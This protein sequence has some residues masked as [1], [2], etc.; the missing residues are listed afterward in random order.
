MGDPWSGWTK[1]SPLAKPAEPDKVVRIPPS[2]DLCLMDSGALQEFLMTILPA[3]RDRAD[4]DVPRRAALVET[5]N[6]IKRETIR[7]LD[8]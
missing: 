4:G 6:E 7:V 2:A 1:V 3:W 8:G 5:V